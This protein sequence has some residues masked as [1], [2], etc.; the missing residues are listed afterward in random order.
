MSAPIG[1]PTPALGNEKAEEPA[2]K[3]GVA[4]GAVLA[5]LS[6]LAS[7]GLGLTDEQNGAIVALIPALAFLGPVVSGWITRGKVTPLPPSK[8]P[9]IVE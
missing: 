6:L 5:V 7:F 9:Q 2:L 8:H 3:V 4:T 1:E